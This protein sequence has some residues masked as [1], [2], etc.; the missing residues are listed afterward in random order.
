MYGA[1][2]FKEEV[3]Y[4]VFLQGVCH[5]LELLLEHLPWCSTPM[6]V[7]VLLQDLSSARASIAASLVSNPRHVVYAGVF[8]VYI[9]I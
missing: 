9:S 7:S 3:R 6:L 5:D 8:I 1:G 4:V 2:S